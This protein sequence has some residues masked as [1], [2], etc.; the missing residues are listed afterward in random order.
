VTLANLRK[1]VDDAELGG[2][3]DLVIAELQRVTRL[4]NDLLQQS[5]QAPEAAREVDIERLVQEL[6]TLLRYQIPP[7]IQLSATV[8]PGLHCR[9]PEDAVR[10]ALLNLVFNSAQALHE[11]AGT[12][13][14]SANAGEGE[15]RI[16]VSDDGP[17]FPQ[18]LLAEGIRPF[19]SFRANGTGL[20]LA[21]VK[22]FARD[23]GGELT[24]AN[25]EPHGAIASIRLP[26][27]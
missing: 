12:I 14:I 3:L 15:L 19:A 8:D 22:R 10:Q 21:I 2:R 25:R 23:Q 7:H 27:K 13:S 1:D 16:A 9:L 11:S 17:G 4:L 5:S 26:C 6:V 18:T 24:I 20:G